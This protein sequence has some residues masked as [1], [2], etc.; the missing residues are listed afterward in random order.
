MFYVHLQRVLCDMQTEPNWG[1]VKKRL[2]FHSTTPNPTGNRHSPVWFWTGWQKVGGVF[3][4]CTQHPLVRDSIYKTFF[5]NPQHQI[6]YSGFHFLCSFF[7]WKN[8]IAACPIL[9]KFSGRALLWFHLFPTAWM[10]SSAQKIM[11]FWAPRSLCHAFSV[12]SSGKLRMKS[13]HKGREYPVE[14]CC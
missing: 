12:G 13:L 9:F 3:F 5:L 11:G 10:R 7:V 4:G 14:D 1:V 6:R 8:K 2:F